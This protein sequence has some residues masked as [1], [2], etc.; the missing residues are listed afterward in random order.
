MVA[1]A[2]PQSE[3][4]GSI[5]AVITGSVVGLLAVVVIVG[6]IFCCVIHILKNRTSG[7][8][9]S[10]EIAMTPSRKAPPIRVAS[11]ALGTADDLDTV[12]PSIPL[13]EKQT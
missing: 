3:Q 7:D 4:N 10:T 8:T 2:S 11:P 13:N 12:N 6:V 9:G 5:D 1:S